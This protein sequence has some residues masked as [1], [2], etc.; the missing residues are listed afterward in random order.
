[1]KFI[2][3]IVTIIVKGDSNIQVKKKA[4]GKTKSPHPELEPGTLVMYIRIQLIEIT[5][6]WKMGFSYHI[7]QLK[8]RYVPGL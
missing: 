2:T 5:R 6:R 7:F 1:M 3:L 8:F 4:K